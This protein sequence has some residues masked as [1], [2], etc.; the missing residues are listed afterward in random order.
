MYARCTIRKRHTICHC[1]VASRHTNW[2][3]ASG[4]LG[5]RVIDAHF[6]WWRQ[7]F[8]CTSRAKAGARANP[9]SYTKLRAPALIREIIKRRINW[10]KLR[11]SVLHLCQVFLIILKN[12]KRELLKTTMTRLELRTTAVSPPDLRLMTLLSIYRS[13]YADFARHWHTVDDAG[14]TRWADNV[15]NVVRHH[16]VIAEGYD[17]LWMVMTYAT[18][19]DEAGGTK[20]RKNGIVNYLLT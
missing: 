17:V 12:D 7:W 8:V 6:D 14:A 4:S 10:G 3:W 13:L 18:L 20:S 16:E 1:F 15:T 9:S 2:F 5:S 11:T 19:L